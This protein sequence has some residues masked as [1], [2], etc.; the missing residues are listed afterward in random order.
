MRVDVSWRKISRRK[1]VLLWKEKLKVSMSAGSKLS[2]QRRANSR[3]LK[4][5]HAACIALPRCTPE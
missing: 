1:V 5:G 3:R 4:A 2:N